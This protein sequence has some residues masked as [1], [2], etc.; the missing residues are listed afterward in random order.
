MTESIFEDI[1]PR[2]AECFGEGEGKSFSSLVSS[3]TARNCS[4]AS[5][6]HVAVQVKQFEMCVFQLRGLASDCGEVKSH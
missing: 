5:G 6:S 1:V 2:P 3:A 4:D